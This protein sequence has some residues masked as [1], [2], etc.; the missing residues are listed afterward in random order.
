MSQWL[1]Q[2][3]II[4]ANPVP[5]WRGISPER[6]EPKPRY[7][8]RSE[9][10][11]EKRDAVLEYIREHAR[12]TYAEIRDGTGVN[13]STVKELVAEL[14]DTGSVEGEKEGRGNRQYWTAT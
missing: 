3:G 6:Y 9:I 1:T 12:C 13:L 14:K 7:S 2:I 8:V 5:P 10:R 4:A 11:D